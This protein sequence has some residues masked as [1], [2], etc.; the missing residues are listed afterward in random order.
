M[1]TWKKYAK[2][3][4]AILK[5][6]L[7]EQGDIIYASG[8]GTP[9]ALPHGTS[10]Q[11][12]KSGGD[13]AN[14]S[15]DTPAGGSSI[16]VKAETRAMDAVSGDVAY[17]GYG[18]TPVGLII[19]AKTPAALGSIGCSNPAKEEIILYLAASTIFG[20]SPMV[21]LYEAAGKQQTGRVKTYDADGFT[22][23]WARTG[24]TAAGTAKL[25][26]FAFK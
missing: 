22:L 11:Y 17:T 7:T 16:K 8:A 4:D 26:V 25:T 1:P 14:P 20:A 24:V 12:L 5:S 9:A 10:S 15:W 13:A 6:L 2:A 21:F 3:D 23:T 19:I 18:F